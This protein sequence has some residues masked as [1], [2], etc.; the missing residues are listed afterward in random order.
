MTRGKAARIH[1]AAQVEPALKTVNTALYMDIPWIPGGF[2]ISFKGGEA[3]AKLI[4]Y[5]N[6]RVSSGM[7]EK[8]EI[9]QAGRRRVKW[10]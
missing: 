5:A 10:A 4:V 7:D 2:N 6:C 8:W 9:T 3:E 1:G